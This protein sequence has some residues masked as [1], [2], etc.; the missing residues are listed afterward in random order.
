MNSFSKENV[1]KQI[2]FAFHVYM[3]HVTIDVLYNFE[4]MSAIKEGSRYLGF[5][6][7][8]RMFVFTSIFQFSPTFCLKGF[9]HWN[10]RQLKIISG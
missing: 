9:H 1:I 8:Y 10:G 5:Q 7:T 2:Y 4:A 6:K 3:L